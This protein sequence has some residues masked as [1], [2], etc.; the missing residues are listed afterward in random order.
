MTRAELDRAASMERQ[1]DEY[2]NSFKKAARKRIEHGASVR[3]EILFID[4]LQQMEHIGDF[5]F[6]IARALAGMNHER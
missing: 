6:N 3:G 5:A 1:I 2:R 4:K